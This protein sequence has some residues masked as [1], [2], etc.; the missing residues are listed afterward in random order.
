MYGLEKNKNKF[1]FDLEV[2]LKENPEKAKEIFAKIENYIKE[3][4][5]LIKKGGK[6]EELDQWGVLLNG[7]LSL[8]KVLNKSIKA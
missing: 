4:K 7:Y 8:Q 5:N 6:K 3:L 1:N 2:E